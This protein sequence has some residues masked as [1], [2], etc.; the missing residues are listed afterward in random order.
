VQT[1]VETC[2]LPTLEYVKSGRHAL[3]LEIPQL[4]HCQDLTQVGPH[5]STPFNYLRK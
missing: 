4:Q 2:S 3:L 1:Q 5:V